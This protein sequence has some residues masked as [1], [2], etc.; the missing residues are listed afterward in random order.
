MGEREIVEKVCFTINNVFLPLI[1]FIA[2]VICTIT[3]VVSLRNKTKWREM[4]TA[5]SKAEGASER[6]QKVARMIVCISIL[7]IVCFLPISV[8]ILALMA[9]P[10]LAIDG[11]YN[12]TLI[13]VCS[14]GFTLESANS[15]SNILIYYNMSS[16]YRETFRET[17]LRRK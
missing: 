1:V 9:E 4:S 2:V 7:F 3:L 16:K 15:A 12:N 14:I 6:D 13:T 10:D 5:G 11:K 8:I 17:V